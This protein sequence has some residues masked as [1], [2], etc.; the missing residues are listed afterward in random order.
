MSDDQ[1]QADL[2]LEE[3]ST[4]H[5]VETILDTFHDAEI[6]PELK[7]EA[8]LLHLEELLKRGRIYALMR[9]EIVSAAQWRLQGETITEP[10]LLATATETGQADGTIYTPTTDTKAL[11]LEAI[12]TKMRETIDTVRDMEKRTAPAMVPFRNDGASNS[13]G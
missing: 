3:R 5:L 12:V 4:E 13:S 7:G 10:E 6:A 2:D 1:E 9:E 8:I 11:E